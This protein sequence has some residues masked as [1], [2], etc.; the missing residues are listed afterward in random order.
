MG[1]PSATQRERAKRLLAAEG[2]SGSNADECAAAAWR[3]Y[4]KLN[5]RLTPLLGSA[6]VQ[7]LFARSAKLAQAEFSSLADVAAPEGLTTLGTSLQTLDPAVATEAAATLFAIF[8]DLIVTFI[9]ERLAVLV[10]RSAWPEIEWSAPKGDK[11]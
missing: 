1:K 4:E 6:G 3:V 11:E 7:A 2:D 10:L 8:I 9:G 5:A